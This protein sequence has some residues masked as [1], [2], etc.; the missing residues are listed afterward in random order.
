MVSLE[1]KVALVTGASSGIGRAIARALAEHGADL[2]LA[3]RNAA[4]LDLTARAAAVFGGRVSIFP[5]DL[6]DTHE[7]N[8][9]TEEVSNTFDSIDI[10]VHAAGAATYGSVAET[11]VDAL[12][13]MLGINTIAPYAIT[14]AFLPD[15]IA[16]RGHIVFINSRSGFTSYPNLT[17]YCA[18]KHA[19]LAIAN[20]LREEVEEEGVRVLS[21]LPGKVATP[22]LETILGER[23]IDY[24][25]ENYVQPE[26]VAEVVLTALML[27]DAASMTDV[28]VK[29]QCEARKAN[30][31]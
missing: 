10:L 4:G 21:I 25:P 3:A 23:G 13:F 12:E 26:D 30:T 22:M 5:V 28:I 29:P 19:L 2:A 11:P 6:A 9:L 27:P 24:L 7:R 31:Q 20:G 18:S 16:N 1:G 17:H 14:H 15:L 8:L